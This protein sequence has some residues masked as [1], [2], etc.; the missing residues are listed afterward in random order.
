MTTPTDVIRQA[1]SYELT[2]IHTCLPAS[3]VSYDYTKQKATVQPLLKKPYVTGGESLPEIPNVPVIFPKGGGFSMHFPLNAGDVV[4]L[5]FSERSIDQ[6]LNRGGEILPLDPRKF[7]LSDAIA[8]PGLMPF[9]ETSPA[10]D[11]TNFTLKIGSGTIKVQ[12]S[13]KFLFNGATEELM[14]IVDELFGLLQSATVAS[15]GTPFVNVASFIALRAR[16]NTLKGS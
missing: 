14:N 8:I 9:S 12:P 5:L 10:E 3:I 15:F 6:W 1:I 11:N 13:G 2:G 7:D 4:L 16:F